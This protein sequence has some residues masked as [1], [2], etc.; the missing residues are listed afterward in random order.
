MP[1]LSVKKAMDKYHISVL[2]QQVLE[3]LQVKSGEKYIDATLG[4]G[5]H[6]FE[7]LRR[8]GK[9]LGLDV[10][11]DALE[12]V[13]SK[14]MPA[15]RQVESL[16]LEGLAKD[17]LVVKRSNFRDIGKIARENGFEKVAGILF[18]L[19]VSSHQVD[20]AER[21]F[22]FIKSG[23]LDMRMDQ[24]LSVQAKD[25]VNGLTR[26]ELTDLFTRFGEERFARKIATRISEERLKQPIETTDQLAALIERV[27]HTKEGQVHPATRVFQALRILINDE[28]RSLEE[29]LPQAVDLLDDSGRLVVISFHSLEDRIVKQ[30]FEQLEREKKGIIITKKPI[31]PTDEEMEQNRRSRS[32]KLRVF[33]RHV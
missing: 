6:T 11:E 3:Y 22:S 16:K 19:G 28:L 15:G 26:Q 13:R 33:E 10:D 30:Q 8:G 23:P 21:G 20:T 9:V 32:S 24:T 5:G 7:I 1:K 4:G 14:A 17:N 29:A 27:V 31:I 25:L 2:L 12:Y 18:D